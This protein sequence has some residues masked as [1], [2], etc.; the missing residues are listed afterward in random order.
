MYN[1]T[2]KE[3]F[4][5]GNGVISFM[6]R[7]LFAKLEK[8]KNKKKRKPLIIQVARQ[9]GKTWI[10][11]EFGARYFKNTIYINFDNNEIMKKVFE[12]DFD[13]SRIISA[14][15]IEFGKSF[16][17]EDTLIIFDEIQEAPKALASLKYFNENAS[18]YAI[19]A[20]G[21]LL[22]VALHQGTSFPV[23]KVDFMHLYPLNFYEF[24]CA[25]GEKQLAQL[26]ESNDYEMINAY[27][28]KY[29]EL[30][31]KYYYVGGMPEAV[32]TYI[33]TDDFYE[34]RE[35]QKSLLKYYEED[36][37]KHAP[38]E[39][40]PRIMMVWN[41]I[42]S[43][44]AKENRKFMYGSIREGARAK[45]F[46]LAIQW[47]EDAGLIIRSYRITKPDIPLIA[48]MEI[49][50]FKM[51][52]LDVGLLAAKGDI[53]AKVLLDDCRIFEEFKGALTE[54]FVAQQLKASEREL[55]YYSTENSSGEIDFVIQQEMKCIPIEVKAEEN[56]RARSLRAFCEKY[57]PE[58]AIRSSMSNYRKQDWMINVPLYALDKYLDTY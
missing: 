24:L 28:I 57:K 54:Q 49:N 10:M 18:Q 17:V 58:V 27:S 16:N 44:L 9:V 8:W 21:S 12:I 39:A 56:L 15:K 43:Q 38:K 33:D 50:H 30:L 45:D 32:Q 36:F 31:K 7:E 41:S 46:E 23:G 52:M 26:L 29:I 14:I 20:A 47:L 48:Y 19:M 2:I 34:V 40:I 1:N 53:H 22:G 3:N 5:I 25:M 35:I 51:F 11:K 42:P 13:T 37:S 4:Y 55:Y 6:E